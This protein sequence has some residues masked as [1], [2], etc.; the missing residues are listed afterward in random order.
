MRLF[1]IGKAFAK[2]RD[3]ARQSEEL[4]QEA[5]SFQ[6]VGDGGYILL[7]KYLLFVLFGYYNARL[8]VVT[9]P[10]WEGWMTALCALAGEG[11]ALYCINSF[12]R[13]AGGHRAAL[14]LFG[15]L[16]TLFSVT[17]ATIS[18]F[19]L[20][21]HGGMSGGVRFY[22]ERVAFPL[23]FGLLLLASIFIPLT[24]WRKKIAA[25]QAK[26]QVRIA[27]S[28]AQLLSEAAAMRDENQLE[29]E[30][31]A[32][33]E[34]QILLEGEYVGKLEQFADMKARQKAIIDGIAD[35]TLREQIAGMLGMSATE[36]PSA[37]T[38]ARVT[39]LHPVGAFRRRP[40]SP[41]KGPRR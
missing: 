40:G 27:S 9:V 6:L 7:L 1:G 3:N 2:E 39:T 26:A 28:R 32:S 18:F 37:S 22:C 36:K 17:H 24:H 38:S 14:G 23:L 30:R 25:E 11:T 15:A 8:F 35:P 12:T 33:L 4:K 5:G 19:R 10:G 31:I 34:E 13:S 21:S 41:G 29:R 20:E 16:L